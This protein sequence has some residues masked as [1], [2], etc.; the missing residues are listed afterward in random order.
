MTT[1][2]RPLLLLALGLMLGGCTEF[3]GWVPREAIK[4]AGNYSIISSGV[5]MATDKT[6]TDHLV[7][8]NTGKN[9]STVRLEQGRSYCREDEPNPMPAA[10]VTC[11]QTLGDVTCYTQPDPMR[12]QGDE[13]NIVQSQPQ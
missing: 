5:L 7:S 10:N 13:L 2:K 1:F 12:Q 4:T 3:Y 6:L 9:C 11:Y 8:F